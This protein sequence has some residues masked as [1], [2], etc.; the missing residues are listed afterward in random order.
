[1]FI[2]NRP[3]FLGQFTLLLSFH[4]HKAAQLMVMAVILTPEPLQ[5]GL[6]VVKRFGGR[7]TGQPEK[8]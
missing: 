2:L 3:V 4:K 8:V 1:M 7:L 6:D 5:H